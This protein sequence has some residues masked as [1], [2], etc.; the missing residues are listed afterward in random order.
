MCVNNEAI[1]FSV[2]KETRM[3]PFVNAR[4]NWSYA[5]SCCT[6]GEWAHNEMAFYKQ[7]SMKLTFG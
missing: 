4:N 6:F 7:I 5:N 3:N 2:L 1:L